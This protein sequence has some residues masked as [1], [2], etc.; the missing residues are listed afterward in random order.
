[1]TLTLPPPP[2]PTAACKRYC[3]EN[4]T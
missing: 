4:Y 2:D 1:L 3:V